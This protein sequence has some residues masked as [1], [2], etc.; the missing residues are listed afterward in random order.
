[1]TDL[2][3]LTGVL[4]STSLAESESSEMITAF[5]DTVLLG[6][7]SGLA[8]TSTS[9][10]LST[11]LECAFARGFLA[12]FGGGDGLASTFERDTRLS[13]LTVLPSLS[14]TMISTSTNGANGFFDLVVG[15]FFNATRLGGFMGD[16]GMLRV[17]D[18][19]G[20]RGGDMG[21]SMGDS[22]SSASL[23]G[24]GFRLAGGFALTASALINCATRV[25]F[26][27]ER[28]GASR[29]FFCNPTDLTEMR[30]GLALLGTRFSRFVVVD[31]SG[32]NRLGGGAPS[33]TLRVSELTG[34]ADVADDT[35]TTLRPRLP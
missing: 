17:Y 28:T 31:E 15:A 34:A 9:L 1:M 20:F 13:L 22:G 35:S 2:L 11:I 4:A 8:R 3:C 25:F 23:G 29:F 21:I 10:S 32:V 19:S 18:V 5:L 27:G 6:R 12:F 24:K 16:P 7:F 30:L 33:N 26:G 14:S